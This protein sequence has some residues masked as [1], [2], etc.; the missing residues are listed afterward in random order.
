MQGQTY[1]VRADRKLLTVDGF[2]GTDQGL[3]ATR[4]STTGIRRFLEGEHVDGGLLLSRVDQFIQRF[5]VLPEDGALLVATWILGTYLYQ[6]FEHYPYLVL[7]SP[8]KGCGKTTTLDLIAQL[9]FNAHAPTASP[10]EA[11]IYRQPRED[12]GSQIFDELEGMTRSK[13][14]WA[15]ITSVLNVGFHRGAVV[16]RYKQ[17]R[18]GYEKETSPTYVPRAMASIAA[19]ESTLE[20]WGILLM[21]NRKP[22]TVMTERFSPRHLQ[23]ALQDLRDDAYSLPL[24]RRRPSR[25]CMRTASLP[26]SV[27]WMIE[28][29][30]CGNPCSPSRPWWRPTRQTKAHPVL[31]SVCDIWRTRH[32]SFGM[33]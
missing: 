30:I 5:V 9:A 1:V 2:G 14:R 23:A 16:T 12:G 19:L 27:I 33:R 8:T 10:P 20:D 17:T 13:E 7:R 18:S 21:L 11:Q 3:V 25:M 6:V 29:V 4:F 26:L 31:A 32:K 24:P 28:P 15:A 22:L